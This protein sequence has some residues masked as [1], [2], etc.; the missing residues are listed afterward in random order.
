MKL[1]IGNRNYSSWSLRAWLYLRESDLAFEEVRIPLFTDEWKSQILEHSPA[2]RVPVLVDGEVTVWDTL[3][4]VGHLQETR[5]TALGWPSD[6]VARAT[7][8]SVVAEMHSGFLAIRDEL[9]QNVRAR[10]RLPPAQLSHVAR[11]QIDRVCEIWAGPHGR[12]GEGWIFGEK[13]VAD[14]FFAP[15]ALRFVT[16]GIE[17]PP[18]AAGF[19]DAVRSLAS[20]QEWEAQAAAEVES[21][22]FVDELVPASRS[23]LV[24]G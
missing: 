17:V 8:R 10:R 3:A 12:G 11:T 15:V 6:P 4:I 22:S 14:I 9:P 7:A 2:A 13:S 23:P 16:Y 5:P 21:L 19:M 24:L 1:V 20:V 18:A